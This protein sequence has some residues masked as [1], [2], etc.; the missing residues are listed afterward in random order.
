MPGFWSPMALIIPPYVSAILGAGLPGHGTLE[1]PL[2]TTAPKRFR[3][4]NSPYSC[5]EPKVPDAVITGFF[6]STPAIL[7]AVFIY[8]STS[9]AR[10]TG[11]S[12]QTR[13]LWTLEWGSTSFVLQTQARHAPMPQAILSSRDR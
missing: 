13:A 4:T 8:S 12:L 9:S 11:P 5:P 7:T 10:N 1:T 2:V 6:S 3:S